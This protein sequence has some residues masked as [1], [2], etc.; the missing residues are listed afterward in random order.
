MT[1]TVPVAFLLA[2]FSVCYRSQSSVTTE[3]SCHCSFSL[4]SSGKPPQPLSFQALRF[5]K[6][7]GH[8]LHIALYNGFVDASL[9][10]EIRL[11]S[12]RGHTTEHCSVLVRVSYPEAH[13]IGLSLMGD[14]YW[15]PSEML[16]GLSIIVA[17]TKRHG[18][19]LLLW[20]ACWRLP[21]LL[22][23]LKICLRLPGDV[24][25]MDC[26]GP[27]RG[28]N[29]GPKAGSFLPHRRP[30]LDSPSARLNPSQ[31]WAGSKTLLPDTP[32]FPPSFMGSDPHC[33]PTALLASSSFLPIFPQG[34]HL[35][36]LLAF[37]VPS[38]QSASWRVWSNTKWYR[39]RW[40]KT[41]W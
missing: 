7:T 4:L 8:Y 20:G 33:S 40:L 26:S 28:S 25:S 10:L 31:T 38:W 5:L 6:T 24:F 22:P 35:A 36:N 34:S 19:T 39:K 15:L 11:C 30:L 21:R 9:W 2:F 3:F 16:S 12:F 18:L 37:L 14:I 32:P 17:A 1:S 29:S 23:V 27:V 41:R 13:D